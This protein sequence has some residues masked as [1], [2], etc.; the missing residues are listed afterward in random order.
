MSTNIIYNLVSTG[1]GYFLGLKLEVLLLLGH[2][3]TCL[4]NLES[5]FELAQ[6]ANIL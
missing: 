2:T 1:W 5:A 6:E 3:N 4:T